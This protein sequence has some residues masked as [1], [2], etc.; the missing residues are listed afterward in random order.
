MEHSSVNSIIV[1]Y[2]SYRDEKMSSSTMSVG[3]NEAMKVLLWL[4]V[5]QDKA[6]LR[7]FNLHT[8]SDKFV[9]AKTSIG[10]FQVTASYGDITD[11]NSQSMS[12]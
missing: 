11:N 12:M 7:S 6:Y 5:V 4:L 8:E 1:K 3:H 2:P 9:C 10:F